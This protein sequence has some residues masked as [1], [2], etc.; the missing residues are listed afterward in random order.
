MKNEALHQIRNTWRL[1]LRFAALSF[2][3]CL[4]GIAI[5]TQGGVVTYS[6]DALN[7]VTGVT[8]IDNTAITFN[9]DPVDNWITN[10]VSVAA[11]SVG[12]GIP[13]W[14]RALYFGGDGTTTNSLSCATCDPDHD[15]FDNL[16]EYLAGTNPRD[17]SSALRISSAAKQGTNMVFSFTT[18]TNRF[19]ALEYSTNLTSGVWTSFPGFIIGNGAV[20]QVSDAG[21]AAS[22]QRFY[23]L[24]LLN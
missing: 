23:R 3:A 4:L 11:D 9:Y 22:S 19:Y 13:N 17:P 10:T 18:A 15:G 16:Q 7:R 14:W 20:Q 24:R 8:Y 6:Y 12:D 2:V 1:A 21:G 5:S